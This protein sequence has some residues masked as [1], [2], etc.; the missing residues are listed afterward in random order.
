MSFAAGWWVS[1][2]ADLGQPVTT[3]RRATSAKS[4]AIRVFTPR[5]IPQ[6]EEMANYGR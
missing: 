4:G 2:A 3:R 6:R 1:G 5:A